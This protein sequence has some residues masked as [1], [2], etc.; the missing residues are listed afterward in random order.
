MGKRFEGLDRFLPPP[1]APEPRP[2]TEDTDAIGPVS[3]RK[4]AASRRS[5]R[6]VR[7]GISSVAIAV[8]VTSVAWAVASLPAAP[9]GAPGSPSPGSAADVS[10]GAT[11]GSG[12]DALR[13]R[14]AVTRPRGGSKARAP[15]RLRH[16]VQLAPRG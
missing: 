14:R 16:R 3:R 5:R 12:G 10:L 2:A 1:P 8:A 7:A 13:R 11:D 15:R 6:A 4:R 9:A